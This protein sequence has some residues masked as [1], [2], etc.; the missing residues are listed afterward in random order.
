MPQS[1]GHVRLRVEVWLNELLMQEDV[2]CGDGP[3]PP[4]APFGRT[5]VFVALTD[6]DT[7]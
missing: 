7:T 6:I 4:V 3:T 2:Y 5:T 1:P